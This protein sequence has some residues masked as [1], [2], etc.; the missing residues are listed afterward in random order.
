M[1]FQ[2]RTLLKYFDNRTREL[3]TP[4]SQAC[5][6]P[7]TTISFWNGLLVIA[8]DIPKA[9]LMLFASEWTG[10]CNLPITRPNVRGQRTQ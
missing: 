5:Y 7:Q 1:A 2:V 10:P 3:Y 8:P 4:Y 6:T 9:P